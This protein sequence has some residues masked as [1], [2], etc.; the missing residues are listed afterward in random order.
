MPLH[1]EDTVWLWN[2]TSC[3][4]ISCHSYPDRC[5]ASF[6]VANFFPYEGIQICVT[7]H[8]SLF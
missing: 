8:V 6:L 1:E 7:D 5:H 2:F 4:A 3:E